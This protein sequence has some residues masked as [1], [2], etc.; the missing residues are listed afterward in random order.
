MTVYRFTFQAE[1][2]ANSS[3]L[4]KIYKQIEKYAQ[5]VAVPPGGQLK[6]AEDGMDELSYPVHRHDG[7]GVTCS[8]DAEM[9]EDGIE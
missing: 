6:F 7:N 8:A 2:R 9:A 4:R 3:T 1:G 5:T